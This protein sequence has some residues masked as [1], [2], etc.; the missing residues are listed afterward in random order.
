[1]WH[2]VADYAAHHYF[3][4][5]FISTLVAIGSWRLYALVEDSI[6]HKQSNL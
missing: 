1:M 4:F 5:G 2:L 6:S 3:M